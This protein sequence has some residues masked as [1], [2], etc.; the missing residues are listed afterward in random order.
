MRKIVMKIIN[1]HLFQIIAQHCVLKGNN[2]AGLLGRST[3]ILI[4]TL[5]MIIEDARLHK[6]ELWI[7]LQDLSKAYDRVDL[8]F[9][10]KAMF[11]LKIPT[12][13]INFILEFF[14]HKTN[15][16]ITAN[17]L[18]NPYKV[19]IGIDQGEIISPLLFCIYMDPLLCE[20]NKLQLGYNIEYKSPA[21]TLYD[22]ITRL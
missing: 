12:T 15:R 16:V 5:R 9:L 22:L 2:F 20:V 6:K 1:N 17:G 14:T 10:R 8:F 13:L 11:R 7:V 4:R 21:S 3:E 18:S 19:K